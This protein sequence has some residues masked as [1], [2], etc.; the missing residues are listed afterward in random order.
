LPKADSATLKKLM[1]AAD[2]FIA[3]R[4]STAGS[5]IIAGYHWFSDWGRDSMI[6]LFGLCLATGR[7]DEGRSI[8]STFGRYLSEGMLPNY[9]PDGGQAPEYNTSDATLWWAWALL[10]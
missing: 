1:L 7:T 8:L 5:T 10:G 3:Q 9:F 6:S 4:Q 2:Q